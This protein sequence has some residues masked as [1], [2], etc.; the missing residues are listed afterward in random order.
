LVLNEFTVPQFPPYINVEL[1]PELTTFHRHSGQRKRS[2]LNGILHNH[3]LSPAQIKYLAI[4]NK[5][6]G[7]ANTRKTRNLKLQQ[8]TDIS[9]DR[10][11]IL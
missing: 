11:I 6:R 10:E 7:I 1:L 8:T 5:I 9:V 4:H 3:V 2:A